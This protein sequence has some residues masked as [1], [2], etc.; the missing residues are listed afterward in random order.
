M[1][2]PFSV[3]RGSLK[4]QKQNPSRGKNH[5]FYGWH[6]TT[7]TRKNY[8]P[9]ENLHRRGKA[10]SIQ[11]LQIEKGGQHCLT[12]TDVEQFLALLTEVKNTFDI[13]KAKLSMSGTEE[14][15]GTF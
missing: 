8:R 15:K 2:H 13:L 4:L 11:L 9:N 1:L 14:S 6:E 12:F 3:T 10:A 5:L 7:Q